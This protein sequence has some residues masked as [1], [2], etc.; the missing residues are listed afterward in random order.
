MIRAIAAADSR[1]PRIV[2][3][4]GEILFFQ[5][6]ESLC[7]MSIEGDGAASIRAAKVAVPGGRTIG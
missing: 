6:Q 7:G 4:M 3:F 1:A 2:V 5:V